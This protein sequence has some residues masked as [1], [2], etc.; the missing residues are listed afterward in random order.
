MFLWI[1]DKPGPP[2][3]I[4][5]T[6]IHGKSVSLTWSPPDNDGGNAIFNYVVE[7]KIDGGFKWTKANDKTV[8]DCSYTV[9]KLKEDILYEFRVSAE[10]KAGVGPP[11]DSTKPTLTE[12]PV[13]KSP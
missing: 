3:K 6:E 8:S 12:E 11:S 1:S 10:N 7:F 4:A 2:K 5:I 9:K 13:G